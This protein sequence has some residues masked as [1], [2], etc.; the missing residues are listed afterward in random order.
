MNHLPIPDELLRKVFQYI[1]PI[2][3]YAEHYKNVSNYR[4]ASEALEDSIS[5]YSD[6]MY[7]GEIESKIT[8]VTEIASFTCLQLEYLCDIKNFVKENPKFHRPIKNRDLTQFQYKRQFDMHITERNMV[9]LGKNTV[10]WRGEWHHPD[11]P[12]EINTFNDIHVLHQ[13]GT[14]RD[15]IFACMINKVR[16]F[17]TA[18][19]DFM[20]KKYLINTAISKVYE[21]DYINFINYYYSPTAIRKGRSRAV[22]QKRKALVKKLMKL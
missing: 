11:Q 20:L 17:K 8:N 15:L 3:E 2:F 4:E 10:L 16:G 7:E 5:D 12:S 19:N 21:T 13:T 18:F 14:V 9:R 1:H 22:G 6:V